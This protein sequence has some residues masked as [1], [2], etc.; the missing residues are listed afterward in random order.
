MGWDKSSSVFRVGSL[1]SSGYSI[2]AVKAGK[3]RVIVNKENNTLSD[4]EVS[5]SAGGIILTLGQ[6]HLSGD[7]YFIVPV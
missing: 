2:Y 7:L 1:S 6:Q 5:V 4:I 3:Y